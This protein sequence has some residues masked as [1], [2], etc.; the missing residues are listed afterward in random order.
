MADEPVSWMQLWR[1]V[2]KQVTDSVKQKIVND[3]SFDSE[4]R[5]LATTLPQFS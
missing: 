2:D 1:A 3:V 5:I 4:V